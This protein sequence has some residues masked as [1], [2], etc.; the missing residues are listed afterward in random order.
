MTPAD[1]RLLTLVRVAVCPSTPPPNELTT[2][3][4]SSAALPR[5]SAY[6]R[7]GVGSPMTWLNGSTPRGVKLVNAGLSRRSRLETRRSVAP[8]EVP[9]ARNPRGSERA[10]VDEPRGGEHATRQGNLLLGHSLQPVHPPTRHACDA[11]PTQPGHHPS[12]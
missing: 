10:T 9:P 6:R 2:P 7:G 3:P 4:A 5:A 12:P 11:L 8:Y 1:S